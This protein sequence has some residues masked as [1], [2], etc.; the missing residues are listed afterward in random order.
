MI[1]VVYHRKY[2]RLTVEGHAY[3]GEHG[4]DLVCASATIL[5]YTLGAS[6]AN[7]SA[8]KQVRDAKINLKEGSGEIECKAIRRF[9]APV[10]LIFDTVCAGF[11]L[12]ANHYPDNISYKVRG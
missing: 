11:E 4:H 2:H 6:V 5:A 7:M 8:A 10:T 1:A 9:D 12:L 3:S